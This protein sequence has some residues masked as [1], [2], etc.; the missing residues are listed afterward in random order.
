MAQTVPNATAPVTGMQH[1]RI[2]TLAV[3]EAVSITI[4]PHVPIAIRAVT[5]QLPIVVN[6]TIVI[7]PATEA[8]VMSDF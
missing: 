8:K 3:K 7:I 1:S 2:Q 5:I 4:T 6:A